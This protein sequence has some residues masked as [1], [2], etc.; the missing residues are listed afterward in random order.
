MALKLPSTGKVTITYCRDPMPLPLHHI[1]APWKG[2]HLWAHPAIGIV[3]LPLSN[4]PPPSK[5]L[6]TTVRR[7]WFYKNVSERLSTSGK[8]QLNQLM[9]LLDKNGTMRNAETSLKMVRAKRETDEAGM[10]FNPPMLSSK[11]N[12]HTRSR[13]QERRG[14]G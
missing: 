3:R 2:A 1:H 8:R 14:L 4:H 9:G 11:A 12:Y 7:Q 13:V 5:T 6:H 10:S